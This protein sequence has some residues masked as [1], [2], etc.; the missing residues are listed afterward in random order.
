LKVATSEAEAFDRCVGV[1]GV[2]LFPADTVYGLAC[3]PDN[4]FAVQRLYLLKRRPL[5][6]PSA[7]MFFDLELAFATLPELGERTRATMRALLPGAVTLLVPNPAGRFPL[8]CGEDRSTLGV[9]V[10]RLPLLAGA[11]WPVLQSSANRAGGPDPRRI[12]EVP[13]LIRAASDLVI[14][15]GELPGTPSTVIDLRRHEDTGEWQIVR[16]GAVGEEE[17]GRTLGWQFHFDPA[18]YEAEIRAEVPMFD[19]LQ[20]ELV[21]ASGSGARRILELGTGTGETARRLL[22]QHPQALL[23]GIDMS[24]PMLAAAREALP[25]ERVSLRAQ[26]LQDELPAGPFDLVASALCIH[27]LD[28]GEKADLFERVHRVLA[29]GGR[30]AIADVVV[31]A[32]ADDAET[33]LTS[34]YDKPSPVADQLEWLVQA[35]FDA[36]VTW[37]HGD[38]AVIAAQRFPPL[39]S[40]AAT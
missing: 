28:A 13:E 37:E 25:A 34:G 6:K 11:S 40:S 23:M 15:G 39:V 7:V 27:H 16:E 12:E 20:G 24:D 4:R 38:L 22:A 19:R 26:R 2:A 32:D 17:L 33:A 30:F 3:D 18:T 1:G 9:R 14:D 35:G 29:P 31:P 8:A 5:D 10:P 21:L 36:R